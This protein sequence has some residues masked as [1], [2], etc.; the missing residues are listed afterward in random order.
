M[1]A[2]RERKAGWAVVWLYDLAKVMMRYFGCSIF[3]AVALLVSG[4]GQPKPEPPPPR[5]GAEEAAIIVENFRRLAFPL[6][7]DVELIYYH[8]DRERL[9]GMKTWLFFTPTNFDLAAHFSQ[10]QML[11][12]RIME[13]M[14]RTINP[15]IKPD[16][17]TAAKSGVRV[18]W[19]NSFGRYRAN[20]LKTSSGE[21]LYVIRHPDP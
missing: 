5:I 18:E 20:T 11:K 10:D 16:Q 21:Y 6:P 12:M 7:Q 3:C 15:Y 2:Q 13:G 4:C 19:E 9:P 1:R 14:T 17:V 8:L